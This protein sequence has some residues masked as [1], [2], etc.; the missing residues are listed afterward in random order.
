[1]FVCCECCVLSGRGLCDEQI[2]RPEESKSQLS[3]ENKLLVYKVILKPVWTYGIQLWGI[4]S[5]SN[6]EIL[7]RFASK[8][9][10]IITDAPWYVPNTVIKRYLQIPTV[11]QEARKYSANNRKRLD[12]HPNNL[13]NALLQE[14]L[15]TRRLKRLYPADLVTNG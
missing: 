10:R 5:N 2:T 1:M 3:L 14:Q 8:V 6:L 4:G 11:K 15:G 12:A 9:L 7:E 13:A